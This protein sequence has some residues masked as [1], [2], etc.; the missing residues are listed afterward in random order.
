M[1]TYHVR[2]MEYTIYIERKWT[3]HSS[4][5]TMHTN[6]FYTPKASLYVYTFILTTFQISIQTKKYSTVFYTHV[7]VVF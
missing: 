1:K 7:G 3:V 6:N 5:R 2:S 4:C